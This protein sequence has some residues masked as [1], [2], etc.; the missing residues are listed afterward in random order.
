MGQITDSPPS[1]HI[2]SRELNAVDK[3]QYLG[4]TVITNFSLEPEINSRM[5]IATAVM[6][7]LNCI[8]GRLGE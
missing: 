1:N 2:G 8:R 3:F 5:A 6:S 7:R 4:S